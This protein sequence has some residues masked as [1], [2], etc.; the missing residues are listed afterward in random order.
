VSAV[1]RLAWPLAS[2]GVLLLVDLVFGHSF[3]AL[4]M[5]DGHLYGSLIAILRFGAPAMLVALG[6]TAVIATGGIDRSRSLAIRRDRA[7]S[8]AGRRSVSVAESHRDRRGPRADHG[9]RI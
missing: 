7:S 9:A 2:I 5:Q 4:R 6:M 8:S 3:F 1:R